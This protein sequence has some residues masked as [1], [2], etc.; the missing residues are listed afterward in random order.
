MDPIIET[1]AITK[2]YGSNTAVDAIDLTVERG[3][4]F[5]LLGPNGAGKTTML[6]MLCTILRPTSGTATVNGYDILRQDSLVR[7]SIGIVFQD[8]SVDADMTALENLRMHADLYSVP[9]SEQKA[10]IEEVLELVRLEEKADA[11]VSTYSGGMRRRLEIARGLLHY[12]KVLFLD[13]PTIGLDPQSREHIWD[14]IRNLKKREDMTIILTTHYMEEADRLCD[15]VAIV[16]RGRIVALDKPQDL[17]KGLGGD[18]IVFGT[19][20]GQALRDLLLQSRMAESVQIRNGEITAAV[21][22]ASVLLPRIVEAA[23]GAGIHIEYI[24]I[25]HPDMN[26]VFI[27]YTGRDLRQEEARERFGRLAMM[28]RRRS[29]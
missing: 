16:D 17:K 8:P 21:G 12:P 23:A 19:S 29:R 25:S 1:F 11:F 22:N 4:V 13:E 26:D 15:R 6:S 24:H 5:G 28:K 18:T 27:H 14:Y 2:K 9:V 20:D 10:R 7:R 3:E